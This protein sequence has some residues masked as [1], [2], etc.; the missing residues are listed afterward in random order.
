[1]TSYTERCAVIAN[2][3]TSPCDRGC[4]SEASTEKCSTTFSMAC[5]DRIPYCI[6]DCHRLQSF[7]FPLWQVDAFDKW[8]HAH[9]FT[10]CFHYQGD[11]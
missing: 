2:N 8:P 1:M 10:M 9:S 6:P 11:R 5:S 7:S 4:R 3:A